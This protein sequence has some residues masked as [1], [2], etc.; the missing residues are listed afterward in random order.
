[1]LLLEQLAERQIEKHIATEDGATNG[2]RGQAIDLSVDAHVPTQL[3]AL[4]RV[5]KHNGFVPAE[6]SLQQEIQHLSQLMRGLSDEDER[7]R[8]ARRLQLLETQLEMQGR[9]ITP[10]PAGEYQQ[11]LLHHMGESRPG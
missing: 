7:G 2:Y 10:R 6:L 1:M 3:R 4:Y 9:A 8:A 11:Q 5:M